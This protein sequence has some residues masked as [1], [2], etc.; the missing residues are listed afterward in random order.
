MMCSSLR[1]DPNTEQSEQLLFCADSRTLPRMSLRLRFLPLLVLAVLLSGSS[2]SGLQS[3]FTV[4]Q[5]LS[6]PFPTNLV[7]AQKAR[8]VA[9][10]FSQKGEHNIWVADAPN[11]PARQVTH[12]AGDEG[13]PIAA[14]AITPDGQTVV[15]QMQKDDVL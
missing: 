15:K 8:R 14:L 4:E 3:P 11:F 13:L 2:L 9:W 1:N 10:V 5:V 7:A 12:Y 6:S